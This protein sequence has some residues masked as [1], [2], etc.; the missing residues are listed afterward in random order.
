MF[1]HEEKLIIGTDEYKI[2]P[3][4]AKADELAASFKKK[5]DQLEYAGSIDA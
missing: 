4:A 2:A 1:D 5:I 3:A